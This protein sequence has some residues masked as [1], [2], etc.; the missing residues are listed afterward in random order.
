MY[1]QASVVHD[2]MSLYNQIFFTFFLTVKDIALRHPLFSIFPWI[3]V[4]DLAAYH[5]FQKF[6]WLRM[7]KEPI[8]LLE[9]AIL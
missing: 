7:S 3:F 8:G 5:W 2:N 9:T 4:K 1:D 6:D